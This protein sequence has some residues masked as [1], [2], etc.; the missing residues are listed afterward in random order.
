MVPKDVLRQVRR[1]EI[2]T[3]RIVNDVFAG[4]YQSVF[5]GRG[6]EFEEVRQYYPG[7]DVRMIDWNVTARM[8]EPYVKSFVEE[9]QLTV[10][11]LVD[12]SGS[13]MFGS[14][15]RLKYEVAVEFA[16]VLAFAAIRSNDRVGLIL[17]TDEVEEFL[18]PRKGRVHCLRLIRDLLAF[19]PRGKG[20]SISA[21]IERLNAVTTRRAVVFLISD[22]MDHGYQKMLRIANKRHDVVA[23]TVADPREREL[24]GVGLVE[25]ED[26]ETGQKVT[27]NT[28]SPRFRKAF[29]TLASG[30]FEETQRFFRS[31]SI[32]SIVIRSDRPY[33]QE[34]LRFFRMRERRMR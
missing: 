14:V 20:T 32:D 31:S 29:S 16:A 12:A 25:F 1:L 17:F 5:K 4:Q 24:V 21:A 26:P 10:M 34:L 7:D 33:I 18:P 2:Y 13:Q 3:S 22:F 27:V 23:V 19:R 11:L 6:I 8:D 28:S 9:R 15:S 30:A